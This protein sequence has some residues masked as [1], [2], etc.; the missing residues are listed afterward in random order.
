LSGDLLGESR[1]GKKSENENQ[2]AE[3]EELSRGGNGKERVHAA[4]RSI[5][6]KG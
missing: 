2:R 6:M 5:K 4:N 1:G 3:S